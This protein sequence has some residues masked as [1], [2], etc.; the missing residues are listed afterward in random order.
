MPA[1]AGFAS[2]A[3]GLFCFDVMKRFFALFFSLLLWSSGFAQASQ[4]CDAG[5]GCIE[6]DSWQIGIAM[7]LGGRTNP[8]VDG[9][10]I[11]FILLPD[12]AWYGESAYFDNGEL[13]YQW[14][15]GPRT[16]VELFVVPNFEKAN[17][18]FW[19]VSNL[20]V[21][22]ASFLNTST[23]PPF[24]SIGDQQDAEPEDRRLSVDDID[25]R[26]WAFD[27]GIRYQWYLD[28]H[29][30]RLMMARDISSVY[31]GF[32][33]ALEYR[34]YTHFGDWQ[35]TVASQLAWKGQALTD[36]YYGI[37]PRDAA[38]QSLY[39]EG[40]GGFQPAINVN[41]SYQINKKWHVLTRLGVTQLHEGMTDSPVVED[42]TVYSAF[43]GVAYRF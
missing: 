27:A 6:Q 29:H 5:S 1:K 42:S 7:G 33:A 12:I 15:P 30:V 3:S 8:L 14:L 43:A 25:T 41:A 23:T 10:T 13:G 20:L 19:H 40:K 24:Q 35:V 32:H 31:D 18:S 16:S 38:N 39:Y 2:L 26:K 9:D 17:F 4:K 36:Y 22:A 28:N 37:R 34:Y 21:P 11:P